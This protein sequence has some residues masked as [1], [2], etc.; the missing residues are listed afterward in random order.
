VADNPVAA[1]ARALELIAAFRGVGLTSSIAGLEASVRSADS[2]AVTSLLAEKGLGVATYEAALEIKS[3]SARIDDIVHALGILS[4][5]P[6]I[7]EPGE[8]VQGVS[9]AAGNTGRSFDLETDRRVAEFKFSVW[10]GG[11]EPIRQ[12]Q[13]SRT[14]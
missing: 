9:L 8:V 12:N 3:M 4:A 2:A 6:N 11:T 7:L 14:M 13:L 1:L 5:L 10:R